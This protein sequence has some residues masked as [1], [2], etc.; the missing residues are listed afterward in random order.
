MPGNGAG[1]AG[2]GPSP[3]AARGPVPSMVLD[4]KQRHNS[5]KLELPKPCRIH[6]W[7]APHSSG[8]ARAT[9]AGGK[10]PVTPATVSLKGVNVPLAER[11]AK[12]V[13]MADGAPLHIYD[14][15]C[16][17]EVLDMAI[18]MQPSEMRQALV[19]AAIRYGDAVRTGVGRARVKARY[20]VVLLG[21]TALI[22]GYAQH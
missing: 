3:P 18:K 12:G 9:V 4:M 8:L 11:Q 17:T 2:P 7:R 10:Q 22:I 21:M 14:I 19:A 15:N 1:G 6:L 16:H 5:S 13:T 20:G